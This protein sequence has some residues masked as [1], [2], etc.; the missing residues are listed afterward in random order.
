[1]MGNRNAPVVQT[2][3]PE[4]WAQMTPE[5]KRTH[6]LNNYL[7]TEGKRFVS[8][9]AE[10]GYKLRAQRMVDVLNVREPDMVPVNLPLGNLPMSLFG[11]TS[12]DS[13]YDPEK[14][15][16]ASQKFNEKYGEELEVYAGGGGGL[17]GKALEIL[18]YK[19]YFWPGHGIPD[20]ARGW[21]YIEGEYMTVDEYDDLI[22][23]PSDFWI[24]IYL[25][26]VLGALEPLRMFQPFTNITENVHVMQIIN[27]LATPAVQQMLQKMIDG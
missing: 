12:H 13:F 8:P 22:R 27:P 16:I 7:S 6:R 5:E 4:N 1:M 2:R 15:A 20:D 26:R 17:P 21:Q 23:D 3:L 11:A 9:E 18:D 25:P 14:V 10:K 19:I 24:R